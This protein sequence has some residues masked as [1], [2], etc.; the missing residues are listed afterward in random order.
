MFDNR[1]RAFR[2]GV[3]GGR[4]AFLNVGG[5]FLSSGSHVDQEITKL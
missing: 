1:T 3:A 4:N 5:I 2:L